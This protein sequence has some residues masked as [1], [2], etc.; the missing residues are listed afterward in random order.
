MPKT[1][2]KSA[3]FSL[4]EVMIVILIIGILLSVAVPQFSKSRGGARLQAIIANLTFLETIKQQCILEK[5]VPEGSY[6]GMD[7]RDCHRQTMLDEY[8]NG[9]WPGVNV[10]YD[11]IPGTYLMGPAGLSPTFQ[12]RD[13]NW[14]IANGPSQ[15]SLQ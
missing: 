2:R 5:G 12:G 1:S 15:S 7:G 11:P 9:R 13:K 3:G 10:E 6:I 4:V 8:T 14:W